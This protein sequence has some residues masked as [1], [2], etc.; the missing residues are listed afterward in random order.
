MIFLVGIESSCAND[1]LFTSIKEKGKTG[2]GI[3]FD[4]SF[5][6]CSFIVS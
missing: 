2:G 3:Y 4:S 6:F 5:S 1:L